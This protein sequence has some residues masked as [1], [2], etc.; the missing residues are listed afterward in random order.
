[1]GS[2]VKVCTHQWMDQPGVEA[3]APPAIRQSTTEGMEGHRRAAA[4]RLHGKAW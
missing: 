4:L 3:V 1:V 2:F